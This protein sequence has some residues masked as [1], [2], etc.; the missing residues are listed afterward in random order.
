MPVVARVLVV[1]HNRVAARTAL[2]REVVAARVVVVA[3]RPWLLRLS[4]AMPASHVVGRLVEHRVF[5]A[6]MD[7]PDVAGVVAAV[8]AARHVAGVG[9][10]DGVADDA[11]HVALVVEQRHRVGTELLTHRADARAHLRSV[12]ARVVVRHR[13]EKDAPCRKGCVESAD[14]REA[15][16]EDVRQMVVCENEVHLVDLRLGER[17]Q[18][19]MLRI[20]V[21]L[22]RR[23]VHD[24]HIHRRHACRSLDLGVDD[25]PLGGRF[26]G[27]T[28]REPRERGRRSGIRAPYDKK[29]R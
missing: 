27:E 13:A 6:G 29:R 5:A 11:A 19:K 24:E 21:R 16:G 7:G 1:G 20:D 23:V 28:V 2:V 17:L 12:G 3:A 22:R 10:P 14:A 9:H 8:V 26:L 15:V 4:V 18:R 25:A